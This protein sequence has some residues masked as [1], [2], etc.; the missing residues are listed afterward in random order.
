MGVTLLP[1]KGY[2]LWYVID[3]Y[4]VYFHSFV[5]S[6]WWTS[7]YP[8]RIRPIYTLQHTRIH[9]KLYDTYI[10]HNPKEGVIVFY[11]GRPLHFLH[12]NE[13]KRSY[14]SPGIFVANGLK[15]INMT[16]V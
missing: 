3:G 8:Q 14:M 13:W 9:M 16:W 1:K 12:N 4:I 7:S 6:V 5:D 10:L 11:I 15:L 2:G